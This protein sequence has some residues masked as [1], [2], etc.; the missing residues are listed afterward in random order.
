MKRF[1]KSGVFVAALA[2]FGG[3]FAFNPGNVECIAPANPGGGWD[4]TCR[5]G[6]K[7]LYD[8]GIVSR[9]VKVTNMPG[10]GGGVAFAHVV[11]QRKGDANLLVAASPATTLRLAQGKYGDFTADDVRWLAAIG[12]DF[13]VI[14]VKADAPWKTLG[15]LIADIK[16]DPTKIAI[17]G[18]SAVGGQ[19]HMKVLLLAKAAGI[20]PKALKYVPFDGG[21]E[22]LTAMLGGFVQVF[23]GD[24]SE[25]I[26]QMQAGKIRILAVL[27]EQRLKG[28]FANIPTARELGY[29][30]VWAVWRGFY[31]PPGVPDD[32]YAFWVD[33]MKKLEASP[34]WAKIRDES[35]LGPFFKGGADFEAFVKKQVA[36]FKELSKAL[37][38][39]K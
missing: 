5:T 19:D 18:G 2:L 12:A 22:A 7:L 17:G 3:A 29:D 10:G 30:A 32:A 24:A 20:D 31:M 8:L 33:A 38:L 13:G 6:G 1:W 23:P 11:T 25:T 28:D 27:S 9:P 26:G 39:I 4:F 36:D 16:K 35:G 15:D 14:A 34:E 37:G 21:G